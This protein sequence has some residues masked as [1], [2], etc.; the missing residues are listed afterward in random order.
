MK[1]FCI[2][3]LIFGKP[4]EPTYIVDSDKA[5]FRIFVFSELENSSNL[6]C[7][8]EVE[9]FCAT[10]GLQLPTPETLDDLELKVT[11]AKI[12]PLSEDKVKLLEG[13]ILEKEQEIIDDNVEV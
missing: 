7:W 2:I 4:P 10:L 13:D 1:F 3:Q 12:V 11:L 9:S 5:E 8:V 6:K